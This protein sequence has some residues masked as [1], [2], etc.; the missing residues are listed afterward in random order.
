MSTV[1]LSKR[2]IDIL[3]IAFYAVSFTYGFLFNIPEA[4]GVAVSPE[5][6][7]PPLRWLYEWAVAEEPAHLLV[8]L[9]IFLFS[10]VAIDAFIHTPFIAVMIYAI[11][12]E[13]NWIR[14][15]CW[16][17]AGSAITNMYYY[18]MATLLGDHPPPNT[19]YY[20]VFNLPWLLMP[21]LL[22]WRM[23]HPQPFCSDQE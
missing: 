2:P 8:P 12:N 4:L 22:V 20:L 14:L 16:L 6:P 7:W 21:M 3:L 19:F 9:P 10:A 11:I 5:S 23:R 17:F 15:P 18:F 13:K 1:P